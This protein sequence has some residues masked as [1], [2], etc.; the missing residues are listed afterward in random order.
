MGILST[1]GSQL[2]ALLAFFAF[3]VFQ[4]V[5]L[6]VLTRREG[7]P[8]L[9]YLPDYGFRLVLR[10]IPRKRVLTDIRYRSFA[11]RVIGKSSGS[12]VATLADRP[13]DSG[14]EMVL[15]PGVDLVLLSF[16]LDKCAGGTVNLVHTDK[17]GAVNSTIKIT[18]SDKL[19]CDYLATVQNF[20]NFNVN[21]GKRVE[22]N[23]S[24]LS[25]FFEEIALTGRERQFALDRVR[26][27]R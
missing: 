7:R 15:F 27:I 16:K 6:K 1:I 19:V 13:L 23:G 2:L 12:S 22:I 24:S 9:W 11:R 17:L 20:F 5:L 3:P 4:Y 21:M 8:E 14:E 10:N 18:S 26:E 25:S